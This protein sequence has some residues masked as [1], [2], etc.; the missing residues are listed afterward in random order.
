MHEGLR[1]GKETRLTAVLAFALRMVPFNINVPAGENVTLYGEVG[2]I[3]SL[4][5]RAI[6]ML[7]RSSR[8][9]SSH[10]IARFFFFARRFFD[11]STIE[12]GPHT[13]TQSFPLEICNASQAAGAWKS[14]M[15]EAGFEL[16][17][18]VSSNATQTYFCAVPNHCRKGMFG[19]IN[20]SERS[21]HCTSSMYRK[22][23]RAAR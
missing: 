13:V 20:V 12:A 6:I 1:K 18:E 14:G 7:V 16:P 9:P 3:L 19:L 8:V 10:I 21:P 23:L 4:V 2:L 5:S 17:V 22:I 11:C 15:Q